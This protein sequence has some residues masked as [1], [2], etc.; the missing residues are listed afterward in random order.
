LI[1]AALVVIPVCGCELLV[2]ECCAEKASLPRCFIFLLLG[3][4]GLLRK[5]EQVLL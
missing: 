3:E 4:G 2:L 1:V 5:T